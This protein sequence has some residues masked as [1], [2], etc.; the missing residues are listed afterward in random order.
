MRRAAR[1]LTADGLLWRIYTD[2]HALAIF[3]AME[4]GEQRKNNLLALFSY[5]GELAAGG[6]GGLFDFVTHLRRLLDRDDKPQLS[7]RRSGGGVRLMTIH[8]SKG[9][10]FPVVFLTDLQKSFNRSDL[11]EA[12]L[13]HPELG[14]G[15]DCVDRERRI[16]YDTAAKSAIALKLERES[17]AEEMRIL[18]VAMT[19]AKEKLI[20]VDCMKGARKHVGDLIQTASYPADP[21]AVA[22]CGSLGDWVLLPLVCAV[23]GEPICQWAGLTP[24]ADRISA[25]GWTVRVWENPAAEAEPAAQSGEEEKKSAF[26]PAM[27]SYSYAHQRAVTIPTKITATQLKGRELDQEIAE[28]AP[29]SFHTPAFEMPRFLQKERKLSGAERGTAMHLAMQFVDFGLTEK[30]AVAQEIDRLRERHLMTPEQAE[31][32]DCAAIAAFLRSPLGRRIAAAE[33]V[34]REYRFALL[35]PATLYDP[36]AGDEEMLLQGVVDCAFDTADGLVIVDFKT[37]RLRPGG[38]EARAETYRPQLE[39]YAAALSRVLDRPV[40]EKW[41]YFFATGR[42]ISL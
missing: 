37:D 21:E 1:D 42:E 6:K 20:L 29:A 18:Y 11:T 9:L 32:V 26:D 41:L 23:E 3:G 7:T 4:G 25:P 10:E 16:R 15:P 38:E 28:G 2:C 35:M 27:L 22:A 19:R 30:N 34:Y 36:L 17:K 31:A 14:L 8:K 24:P 5:A 39:A 40:A 13:V 12:V 33:T